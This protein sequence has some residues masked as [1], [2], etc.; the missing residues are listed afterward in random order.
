MKEI[1]CIS[2]HYWNGA[3]FRK[4][5]FMS[6][7]NNRGYKI[8]YVEPS[9]SIIR[10][11][12]FA[13]ADNAYNKIFNSTVEEIS[14]DFFVIKP[15]RY[16]PLWSKPY[17]NKLNFRYISIRLSS[18]LEKLGFKDYIL[19]T[20]N[21]E[22][23]YGLNA[24]NYK[25]LVF[26]IVDDLA[27]YT[28]NKKIRYRTL[29]NCMRN[30]A[31]KSDLVLTTAYTLFEEFKKFSSNIHLVPNGFDSG[32]FGQ[33][34]QLSTPVDIS[35]IPKPIVGF[36]GAIF[37]H[38]DFEL[39]NNIIQRNKDKSFVFVGGCE[40]GV[41]NKWLSMTQN[42]P[43]IFWLGK[44][45]KEEI[46]SYINKFDVCIN[47]F[48][49]DRVSR[50]VSPLKVFEYLAMKKPVVSVRMESLEKEKVAP[51]IYFASS[52]QDF[53]DKLNIA[54]N[55]KNEFEKKLDY[56]IVDSYSWDRLF[57]DVFDLIKSL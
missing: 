56:E 54:L 4:Q 3:W 28:Y 33:A 8:A 44:K 27:A 45:K 22:F 49:V 17:L 15:P 55:E 36:V 12:D 37:T 46:P 53:N 16:I 40:L 52:Y 10:K 48:K 51:F 29:T 32:I 21:P 43:N 42:Y 6:R 50:S 2:T 47:P 41:Q 14:R 39:L 38:L 13:L 18:I 25:K 34:A 30:L 20:Y 57:S 5:H 26:D 19:W 7:F 1:V 23:A 11:P 9:F 24:L 35:G 31:V